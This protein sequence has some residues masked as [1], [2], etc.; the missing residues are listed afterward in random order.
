MIELN[1]TCK[2]INSMVESKMRESSMTVRVVSPTGSLWQELLEILPHDFYHL[3]GYLALEAARY[4]AM[5]EAIV[6]RSN[7]K[8][9]F[10]AYLIRDCSDIFSNSNHQLDRTYD[11]ISPYGYPGMLVSEAGQNSEFIRK[12]L[13]LICNYWNENNICSAFI[14]LHPILNDYIS[15]SFID[16]DK[17]I[18]CEQGDV[19]ICNLTKTLEDI[20]KQIRSSHRTKINR[21]IRAG[22]IVKIGS[23]D[24]YLD[25]F[26]D[27]YRETMD[28]VHATDDYYFT[29][30]YFENLAQILGHSIKICVVEIDGEVVATSL[31]TEFSGIVQYYLGGTRTEFLRQSPAIIMFKYIIEWAK[32]RN[33]RF[34][35]LGGGLGGNHDSLYHFKAG[36]SD[37]SASFA[38]IKTIIDRE[39]YDQLIS[40]R[41]KSLGVSRLVLE[42]TSFFPAYRSA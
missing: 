34:L 37:E 9:F 31:I 5:P 22:F 19:V 38:T 1:S 10:L 26:I 11:V 28:R 36:F 12:C 39:K 27:I 14:R 21:L 40:T 41:A 29:K 33:N 32:Q 2:E 23:I 7:E 24:E 35:N 18:L 17:S 25:V 20:G 4:N 15:N 30:A 6:I 8:I 16:D 13:N 42:S 3:P